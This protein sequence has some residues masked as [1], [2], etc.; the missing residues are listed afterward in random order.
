MLVLVLVL[1]LVLLPANVLLLGFYFL[2][3]TSGW[4]LEVASISTF[5]FLLL[6]LLLHAKSDYGIMANNYF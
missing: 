1:V 2:L 5:Y 4:K 3:V 6:L